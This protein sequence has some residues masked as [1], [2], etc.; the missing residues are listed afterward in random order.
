VVKDV[1]GNVGQKREEKY[2]TTCVRIKRSGWQS[3]KKGVKSIRRY[4]FSYW[5]GLHVVKM[6]CIIWSIQRYNK[7]G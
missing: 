6:M 1:V 3:C 4:S 5:Q 7:I 2:F